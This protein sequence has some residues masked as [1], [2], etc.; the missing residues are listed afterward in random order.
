MEKELYDLAI[1][2]NNLY[3]YFDL[4]IK[5]GFH[6]ENDEDYEF[7]K[8]NVVK[9]GAPIYE[10]WVNEMEDEYKTSVRIRFRYEGAIQ[11]WMNDIYLHSTN[12]KFKLP[13]YE[14][15]YKKFK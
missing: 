2:R 12:K 6:F 1:I 14:I 10:F 9:E 7:F 15:D 5:K 13:K 11:I 4:Y 3:K 8:N